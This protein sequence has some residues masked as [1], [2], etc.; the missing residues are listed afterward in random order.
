M[1]G[2]E[3]GSTAEGAPRLELSRFSC[4]R[5]GPIDLRLQAGECISLGGPSGTGKSLL[6]RAIADLDPHEG[7]LRLDGN[8]NLELSGPHWREQVGLL[9]PETAW[10]ARRVGDHFPADDTPPLAALGLPAEA[11][12]WEVTRLSSGE[13]QRLG[14]LRLLAHRPAVLLLD[15]PTASL[16]TKGVKRV[17]ALISD[18]RSSSGAAVLWVS[19]D[20]AQR[21]RVAD[22]ELRLANGRLEPAAALEEES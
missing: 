11:L 9:P 6:L 22:R 18:Y 1:G 14:L 2:S 15:E 21:Q 10:W 16:D 19:H 13:R 8:D 17:E 12:S 7:G 3:T 4:L 20:A 5:V